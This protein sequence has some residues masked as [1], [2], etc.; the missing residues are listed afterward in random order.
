VGI[1]ALFDSPVGIVFHYP[2]NSLYV[3]DGGNFV[4]RRVY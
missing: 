1:A 4:I 2:T 3:V